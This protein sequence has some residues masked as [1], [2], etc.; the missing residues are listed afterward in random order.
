MIRNTFKALKSFL[1]PSDDAPKH[2]QYRLPVAESPPVQLQKV[3]GN[4]HS[5]FE[6]A[7]AR[8]MLASGG[9]TAG[10]LELIGLDDVQEALG[11]AWP[12]VADRVRE[13]AERELQQCL[14][15]ADIFRP[16]GETGYLIHF[17]QLDR[18]EAENKAQHAA[19]SIKSALIAKVPEI[20]E[21]IKVKQFVINLDSS[22]L[23]EHGR[24]LTDVLTER[25]MKISKD[26]EALWKRDRKSLIGSLEVLFSPVWHTKRRISLLNRCISNVTY[27]TT[28]SPFQEYADPDE[29]HS[30]HAEIDYLTLTRS[31]EALHQ[32]AQAGRT[33]FTLIPVNFSTLEN[34]NSYKEYCKLLE[35]MP[36]S[37]K[38]NVIIEIGASSS[39]HSAPQLL[40]LINQLKQLVRYVSVELKIDDPRFEDVNAGRP[41]GIA[42]NLQGQEDAVLKGR[43]PLG[44]LRLRAGSGTVNMVAHGANSIALA[45]AATK[46]G[47]TYIDGPA[48]HPLM[49]EPRAPF[50]LRPLQGVTPSGLGQPLVRGT[51]R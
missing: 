50:T 35:T 26:A 2:S 10:S 4:D 43:D 33:A 15:P 17:E 3:S 30:I 14:D 51:V 24:S 42:I 16:H 37:L 49:R 28:L 27:K 32:I 47:F 48:I 45:M 9:I 23:S 22:S 36:I 44:A 46:A 21:A 31:L 6:D 7:L 11:N 34:K 20:A 41:W 39:F 1:S 19:L 40:Q 29:V 25:L 38:R 13:V 18:A 12:N 8:T 5:A